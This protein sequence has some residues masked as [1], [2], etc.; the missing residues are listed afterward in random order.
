MSNRCMMSPQRP[1]CPCN[2]PID[3]GSPVGCGRYYGYKIAHRYR[4]QAPNH[5]RH[6]HLRYGTLIVDLHLTP[7]RVAF[8]TQTA[9][10]DYSQIAER[11][12]SSCQ[13]NLVPTRSF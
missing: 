9:T 4:L 3:T 1:H 12:G 11:L 10:H 5:P 13:P 2:A 7:I 6:S 8:P